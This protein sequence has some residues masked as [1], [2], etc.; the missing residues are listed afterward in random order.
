MDINVFSTC[1]HAQQRCPTLMYFKLIETINSAA[2]K[3]ANSNF[4]AK[5]QP[6]HSKVSQ[7]SE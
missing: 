4:W 3:T 1:T 6:L 5:L 7:I 2:G